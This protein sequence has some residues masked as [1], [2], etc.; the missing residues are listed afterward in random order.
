MDHANSQLKYWG[1]KNVSP[2]LRQLKSGSEVVVEVDENLKLEN[3]DHF[4]ETING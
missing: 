1:K 3:L 2:V 4:Q